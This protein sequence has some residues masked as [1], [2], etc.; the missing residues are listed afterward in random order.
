MLAR[1]AARPP[2]ADRSRRMRRRPRAPRLPCVLFGVLGLAACA[3]PSTPP[4]APADAASRPAPTRQAACELAFTET[5]EIRFGDELVGYLV[6]VLAVPDGV[7]DE[8]AFAP[9]TALIEDRDLELLGFI[10]PRGTTYRFEQDGRAHAVAFGTRGANI[11]AFF[12]RHGEPTLTTLQ[13]G[14]SAGR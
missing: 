4:S 5:S 10:S 3:G 1:P 7:L 9:G 6:E 11:A 8:R 2:H 14:T 13:P 12:G